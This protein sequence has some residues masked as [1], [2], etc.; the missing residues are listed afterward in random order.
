MLRRGLS[1]A[2]MAV[3]VSGSDSTGAAQQLPGVRAAVA[4]D[5]GGQRG[6]EDGERSCLCGVH[7]G[8]VQVELVACLAQL[9]LTDAGQP[10]PTGM[11]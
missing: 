8:Q 2:G 6:R 7:A 9:E 1:R 4:F 5:G 3:D 11:M 10:E